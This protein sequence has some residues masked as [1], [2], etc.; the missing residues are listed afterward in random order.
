MRHW[1]LAAIALVSGLIEPAA[2]QTKT[3]TA[4][5]IGSC[6]VV[7]TSA[8]VIETPIGLRA[9][10]SCETALGGTGVCTAEIVPTSPD[11]ILDG[12]DNLGE[13]QCLR[14]AGDDPC[15]FVQNG[16]V[17]FQSDRHAT[18]TF[19][20]GSH[21]VRMT[22]IIRQKKVEQTAADLPPGPSFPLHPGRLFD[23]IRNKSSISARLECAMANGDQRIF[24]IVGD[25]NPSPNIVFVSKNSADPT[26]DILTYRVAQ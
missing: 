12:S 18:Q 9:S 25:A 11:N 2:A 7:Q 16:P 8:S 17:I 5:S 14:L 1:T 15:A 6:A 4:P 10:G 13:A 22:A 21:R 26:F 24:P 3:T 23:V 20:A 19:S